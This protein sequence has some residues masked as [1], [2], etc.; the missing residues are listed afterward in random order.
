MV[1]RQPAPHSAVVQGLQHSPAWQAAPFHA[2]MHACTRRACTAAAA[3]LPPT[4]PACGLFWCP[5][6]PSPPSP[7]KLR[8]V[9]RYLRLETFLVLLGAFFVNLCVICVFAEGFYGTGVLQDCWS[10]SRLL[11]GFAAGDSL[12]TSFNQAAACQPLVVL[13]CI[14]HAR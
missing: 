1:L 14:C 8:G 4:S 10:D 13:S 7:G 6:R 9:L 11:S 12:G 2:C 5:R 3:C